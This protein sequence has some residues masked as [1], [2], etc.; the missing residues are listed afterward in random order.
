MYEDIAWNNFCKT[1]NLESFLEYR[2]I[3]ELNE[4]NRGVIEDEGNI[5]NE[6]NKSER[7]S[8]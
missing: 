7:D 4:K 2:K 5:L 8:N 6:L 3:N 1:G